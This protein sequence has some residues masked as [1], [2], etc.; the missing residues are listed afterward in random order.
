ML[1]IHLTFFLAFSFCIVIFYLTGNDLLIV[2]NCK[3][4]DIEI[5]TALGGDSEDINEIFPIRGIYV[6]L[7]QSRSF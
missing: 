5:R 4:K 7:W 1:S 6:R 2:P 3:S